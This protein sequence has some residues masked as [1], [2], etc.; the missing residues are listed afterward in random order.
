MTLQ[1]SA[2]HFATL[3]PYD[4]RE[5]FLPTLFGLR[6]LIIAE[7]AVYHF[8]ERL[9]PYDYGGGFW[10]FSSSGA[11]LCSSRL[12]PASAC[13]SKAGSP[14]SV[15]RS[16][17][18]PRASSRPCSSCRTSPSNTNPIISPKAII[19]S[20]TIWTDIPKHRRSIRQ[21]IEGHRASRLPAGRFFMPATAAIRER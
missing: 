11:G 19:A 16:P 15:A 8:M 4:R 13:G 17:R 1:T 5:N 14:S 12:R 6:H 10:D 3:V 18:R 7:N 21:S 20:M 2:R 9:S